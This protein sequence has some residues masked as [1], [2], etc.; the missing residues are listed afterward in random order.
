MF[1]RIYAYLSL[2]SGFAFI[3]STIASIL[4]W[5]FWLNYH[6]LIMDFVAGVFWIWLFFLFVGFLRLVYAKLQ[7]KS[8]ENALRTEAEFLSGMSK[9]RKRSDN[10]YD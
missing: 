6:S 5:I 4:S 3:G 1:T 8:L 9:T 2:V 10:I 7:S